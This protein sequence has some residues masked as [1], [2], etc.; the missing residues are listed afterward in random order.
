MEPDEMQELE[1]D[2]WRDECASEVTSAIEEMA[3]EQVADMSS[4]FFNRPDEFWRLV[5][6]L[7]R[8]KTTYLDEISLNDKNLN[9]LAEAFGKEFG[10]DESGDKNL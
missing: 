9:V 4:W 2:S 7:S 3:R 5:Y 6:V 8:E 10:C 1:Y